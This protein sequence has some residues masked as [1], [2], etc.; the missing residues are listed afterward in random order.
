M[1]IETNGQDENKAEIR[2][3]N[4]PIHEWLGS[5]KETVSRHIRDAFI[6]GASG[7]ILRIEQNQD[8]NRTP[9]NMGVDC[10]LDVVVRDDWLMID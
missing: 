3:T 7:L 1:E 2:L 4:E 10:E 5:P 8:K 6:Y 9:P